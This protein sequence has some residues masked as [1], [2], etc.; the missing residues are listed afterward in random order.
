MTE[1]EWQVWVMLLLVEQK[2]KKNFDTSIILVMNQ[3]CLYSSTGIIITVIIIII[4]VIIIIITIIIIM[5]S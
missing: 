3:D 5:T 1:A 4:I 2:I